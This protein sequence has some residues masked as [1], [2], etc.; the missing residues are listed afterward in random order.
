MRPIASYNTIAN[1]P[2][3]SNN[4]FRGTTHYFNSPTGTAFAQLDSTGWLTTL[5]HSIG[6]NNVAALSQKNAAGDAYQSL[7]SLNA[8]NVAVVGTTGGLKVTNAFAVNSGITGVLVATAGAVGASDTLTT[9]SSITAPASTDLSLIG[10]PT[11]GAVVCQSSSNGGA[12]L[13]VNAAA[14]A[15]RGPGVKFNKNGSFTGYVGSD[16]QYLG[17][18]AAN[19]MIG[20]NAHLDFY[21]G[22]AGAPAARLTSTGNF[23][24][25][26][27][28]F[29][30]NAVGVLGIGNGTEPA[31]SPAD[32]VQIYSVDLSAGNA[33]L[34]LRTETAVVSE[35]VVSDRT[36]SIRINGT[37][38][39]L[40]LKV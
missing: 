18:T 26:T 14:A 33:T 8:S 7:L 21:S 5:G 1:G 35:S 32:M 13:F 37:T 10:G 15:T 36:L 40:C 3:T 11:T 27:T 29:G 19:F 24:L 30:T 34:G 17:S 4:E 2:I 23:G 9:V 31:S 28:T 12:T 6:T 39:K 16:G 22:F 20:A 38:Y 25:D